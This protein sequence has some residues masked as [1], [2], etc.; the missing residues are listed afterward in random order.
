MQGAALSHEGND[1]AS[2]AGVLSALSSNEEASLHPSLLSSHGLIVN[3]CQLADRQLAAMRVP[4]L[5]TALDG[6]MKAVVSGVMGDSTRE[7]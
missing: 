5:V 4:R 2:E 1:D 6:V 7:F 3:A